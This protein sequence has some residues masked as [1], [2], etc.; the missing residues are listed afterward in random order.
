MRRALNSAVAQRHKD[1][2]IVLVNDGDEFVEEGGNP[3]SVRSIGKEITDRSKRGFVYV[4]STGTSEG[5]AAARN[6]GI[7]SATGDVIAYLDDDD[8]HEVDHVETGVEL[9]AKG[10]DVTVSHL[11]TVYMRDGKPI[12]QASSKPMPM[13]PQVLAATNLHP[14]SSLM[15]RNMGTA[16][17]DPD[18]PLLEDW[19]AW[20]RLVFG[21][22]L[23]V[24]SSLKN[25]G[26]YIRDETSDA[27]SNVGPDAFL[28]A[29][30][31]LV[32]RWE[33]A[34]SKRADAN[35]IRGLVRE[36]HAFQHGKAPEQ[37]S[38]DP[39][40]AYGR[41]TGRLYDIY[42]KQIGKDPFLEGSV[43]TKVPAQPRSML[44]TWGMP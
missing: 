27:M 33:P 43:E 4:P 29:W 8:I 10:A 15:H 28:T 19:D 7:L 37:T 31:R 30:T 3:I 35:L 11:E 22:G 18:V 12:G 38:G 9:M 13:V 36:A 42:C 32:G 23:T 24:D 40:T 34:W 1:I 21:L 44:I 41:F 20:Q 14:P 2:E 6:R 16:I 39:L 17:W 26:Q 25:T 5:V